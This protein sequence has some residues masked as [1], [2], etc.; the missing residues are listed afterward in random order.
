VS[1]SL[2]LSSASVVRSPCRDQWKLPSGLSH[3]DKE[4][5][6]RVS[7]IHT[8]FFP[9]ADQESHAR[10]SNERWAIDVAYL[11]IARHRSE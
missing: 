1:S 10:L 9:N 7:M 11:V 8:A 3:P 4:A 2:A 6:V 5:M